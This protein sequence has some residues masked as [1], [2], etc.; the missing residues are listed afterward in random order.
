MAKHDPHKVLCE[1]PKLTVLGVVSEDGGCES[2]EWLANLD[3]KGQAAIGGR[4]TAFSERGWLVSPGSFNNL[5]EKDGDKVRVDEI[6]HVGQN[7]RLYIADFSPGDVVAYATHGSLKP[8]PKGVSK[9]VKH[10]RKIYE[11]RKK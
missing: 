4:L 11:E 3:E 10:A 5:E 1:G 7:L 6:K 8:K 2:E 9:H